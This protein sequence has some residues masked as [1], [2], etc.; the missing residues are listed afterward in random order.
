VS[1]WC[2]RLIGARDDEELA[3]ALDALWLYLRETGHLRGLLSRD[4]ED[5]KVFAFASRR[6]REEEERGRNP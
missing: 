6:V 2:H 4:E 1:T 5:L 3:Q